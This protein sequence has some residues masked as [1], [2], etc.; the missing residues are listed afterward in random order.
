MYHTLQNPRR[1]NQLSHPLQLLHIPIR[2]HILPLQK[3]RL[4]ANHPYEEMRRQFRCNGLS[5]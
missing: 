4:F 3:P 2:A 5:P 1:L